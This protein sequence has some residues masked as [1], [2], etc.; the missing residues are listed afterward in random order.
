MP[1]STTAAR[2][3]SARR[4]SSVSGTPMW[5]L[6]L[7][8]VAKRGVAAPGAQDA[9]RSSA[10]PWSCRC[11]RSPRSAAA[12]SAA[13]RPRRA[14]RSARRESAT[15]SPAGRLR[16][17]RV[18]PARRRRRPPRPGPGSRARRSARRAAR[19]TG[20]RRAGVR[21]SLCTRAKASAASPT[22]VRRAAA[23]RFASVI[24]ASAQSRPRGGAARR[25]AGRHVPPAPPRPRRV[26][27]R[28]LD[29]GDFLVVLVALAGDQ[30]HVGALR[31]RADGVA[32]RLAPVLDH[33]DRVVADRCR[34][35]SATG[36]SRATRRAG[37]RW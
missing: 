16:P 23:L 28:M 34:P 19:R 21:V 12:R 8:S 29:A 22:S 31:R 17:G 26:G 27:E 6:K 5:L 25:R 10:S 30:H 9:R 32:D 24:I 33:V 2:C 35:G 7:P 18:R 4:R 15:S 20:R 3:A 1:S 37:C 11:C 14:G 36:S 13:A